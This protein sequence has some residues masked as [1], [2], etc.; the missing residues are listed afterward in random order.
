LLNSSVA[1]AC[2]QLEKIKRTTM[3]E[4]VN[5]PSVTGIEE[6]F[7]MRSRFLQA[8]SLFRGGLTMQ[9]AAT[10]FGFTPRRFITRYETISQVLYRAQQQELVAVVTLRGPGSYAGV[11]PSSIT[12]EYV[13]FYADFGDGVWAD[14]GC[15]G[16]PVCSRPANGPGSEGAEESYS[17]EIKQPFIPAAR[18]V[19]QCSPPRVKAVLC[20]NMVPPANDPECSSDFPYIWADQKEIKVNFSHC[21]ITTLAAQQQSEATVAAYRKL[22][23]H[24]PVFGM[25]VT[26][27]IKKEMSSALNMPFP[28]VRQPKNCK[29][30]V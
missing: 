5:S 11:L 29:I 16:M 12:Y 13:R 20:W 19:I 26:K 7:D 17:F 2:G 21:G 25:P 8:Q 6:I 15:K 1:A 27:K 14:M 10:V 18:P 3:K 30:A 24:K 22:V 28:T 23:N 9:T 4:P